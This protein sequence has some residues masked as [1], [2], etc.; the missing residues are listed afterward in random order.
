LKYL[1]SSKISKEGKE[2]RLTKRGRTRGQ[3]V[4]LQT[5]PAAC[6]CSGIMELFPRLPEKEDRNLAQPETRTQVPNTRWEFKFSALWKRSGSNPQIRL[7]PF[8]QTPVS[9]TRIEEKRVG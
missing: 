9:G 4:A 2:A 5:S 3:R 1:G 8:N 6:R 7:R